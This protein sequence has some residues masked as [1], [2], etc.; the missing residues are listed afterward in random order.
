MQWRAMMNVVGLLSLGACASHT[1]VPG[2]GKLAADM[3]PDMAHCRLYAHMTRPDVSFGAAGSPKFVAIASAVAVVGGAIDTAIHDSETTD[4]CM[5]AHGWRVADA[6]PPVGA[7]PNPARPP[8][9]VVATALAA[10]VTTDAP[11][12]HPEPILVQLHY[13]Q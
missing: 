1:Y 8:A 13:V 12:Q 5:Q 7:V 4:D 11:A 9:T 2:P 3:G 10:P 6:T